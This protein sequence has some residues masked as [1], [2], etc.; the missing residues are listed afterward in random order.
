MKKAQINAFIN[1]FEQ[2]I[3]FIFIHDFC[4]HMASVI[5]CCSEDV[6]KDAYWMDK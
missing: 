1:T 5:Q 6:S 4:A 3:W 2:Y